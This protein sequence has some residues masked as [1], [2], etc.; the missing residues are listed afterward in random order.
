MDDLTDLDLARYCEAMFYDYEPDWRTS[1]TVDLDRPD[2]TAWKRPGWPVGYSRVARATWSAAEAD[3]G[4]DAVLAFFGETPFHWHVGPSSGPSDLVDRLVARGLV[5]LARPR[6]MTVALPLP[7]DWPTVADVRIV[8]VSD[9][10]EA[11]VGL[12]LAHHEDEHLDRDVA[13]RMAYLETPGRR[14]GF[15]VA[16]LSEIPVANAGYRYSSDGRC[17]Y[18]TGAETAEPFRGRGIYK[19]VIA[20]RAARAVA[21]G[22]NLASIVANAETSAPILDRHGFVDHGTMPRL[23][24][25]TVPSSTRS[26]VG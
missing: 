17:V 10:K 20:Y 24:F 15:L 2:V 5:V 26:A 4:I 1:G 7:A 25:P 11:R 8:E 13:E 12:R 18:L 22:C 19:S 9:A 3:A 23:A 14:G 21:R 16:Y 6:L